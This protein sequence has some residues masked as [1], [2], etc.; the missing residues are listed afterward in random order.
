MEQTVRQTAILR[1]WKQPALPPRWQFNHLFTHTHTVILVAL[2]IIIACLL[3]CTL[4]SLCSDSL[5][6]CSDSGSRSGV[7]QTFDLF[8]YTLSSSKDAICAPKSRTLYSHSVTLAMDSEKSPL[9]LGMI[10]PDS[11]AAMRGDKEIL[12]LLLYPPIV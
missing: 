12:V 10:I 1:Q 8:Q 9:N 5:F 6:L 7:Y 11:T 2:I 3:R 4:R